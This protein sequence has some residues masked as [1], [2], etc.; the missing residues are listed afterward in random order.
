MLTRILSS[1]IYLSRIAT[2]PPRWCG[3]IKLLW[4]GSTILLLLLKT[5]K[6]PVFVEVRFSL[7]KLKSTHLAFS[8]NNETITPDRR[9]SSNPWNTN[10]TL[11]HKHFILNNATMTS[12]KSSEDLISAC[13]LT[14]SIYVVSGFIKQC[15]LLTPKFLKCTASI[16]NQ[17]GS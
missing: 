8:Q 7:Y 5:T 3:L 14:A 15:H 13:T 2:H 11:Y 9:F 12:I 1:S 4:Q 6:L 17:S 10:C 16:F